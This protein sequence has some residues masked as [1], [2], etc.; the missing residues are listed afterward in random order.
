MHRRAFLTKTTAAATATALLP[1]ALFAHPADEKKVRLAVIGVGARG[2]YHVQESLSQGSVQVTAIADID[3][4]AI[5]RTLDI[6]KKYQ[7]AEPAVYR[8]ERDFEKLVQRDDVDAVI[9]ATPW[10]WH[11]PMSLAALRAGKPTGCEVPVAL[12]V[13]DCW[14]IVNTQEKTGVP[15]MMLENVCYRRDVMAVLNMAR[16]GLFGRVTYAECGYQHDLR[17]VLFNDG[18]SA[19]GPGLEFGEK[20][21]SEARWRTNFHLD[22]NGELYPTHGLGPV[23]QV[24]N[25]NH[26]N[27]LSYLTSMATPALS[28]HEY[29]VEKGGPDH[30]NAKVIFKEGDVVTTL[31]KCANG[32]VIKMTHDVSSPRP[33][34]LGFRIQGTKGLWTEDAKG[35]Y[36]EGKAAKPHQYDPA[37]QYFDQ[38]DHPIWKARAS[39]ATGAGHGGM[40][41]FLIR[42][43]VECVK[44]KTPFPQDVYDAAAWSVIGPLS[45][46]SIAQGSKP[47][48]IP[49]FTRGKWKTRKPEFGV[50]D[51]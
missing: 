16:Q 26:G 35:I 10:Q 49:D 13:K 32:E 1:N 22:H 14:E 15:Y 40:D 38:Y 47:M 3:P 5:T 18:K 39:E 12:R 42:S 20:G 29:I 27:Q 44:R 41:Y 36:L 23:A 33:Y 31:I 9:I 2:S 46:Q 6:C 24:L 50:G 45:E 25:I 51:V 17:G 48:D 30:P 43:F 7:S 34:S 37:Q 11:A 28:L 21:Y 8:G 19:Y 4:A